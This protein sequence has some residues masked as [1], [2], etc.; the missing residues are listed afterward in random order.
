MD[1]KIKPRIFTSQIKII[2]LVLYKKSFN[3]CDGIGAH[4]Y[5]LYRDIPTEKL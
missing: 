4:W 1:T 5:L 2:F 3:F